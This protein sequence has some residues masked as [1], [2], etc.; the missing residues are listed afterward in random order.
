M[1]NS[2]VQ[3][4]NCA[5]CVCSTADDD[6]W[7]LLNNVSRGDSDTYIPTWGKRGAVSFLD[8]AHRPRI[9]SFLGER[10][11]LPYG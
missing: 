3:Q 7:L 11:P 8:E 4:D 10:P 9:I 1:K 2:A 6:E 5:T